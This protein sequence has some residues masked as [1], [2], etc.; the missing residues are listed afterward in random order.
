MKID[1]LA[2]NNTA[3]ALMH[4]LSTKQG[5]T[6]VMINGSS[7]VYIERDGEFIRLNMTLKRED[8][9]EFCK[10]I[11]KYNNKQ[12]DAKNP[13]ID[14]RLPDGSR[15]N[16]IS[17]LYTTGSPAITIRKYLKT[18]KTFEGSP[19]LFGIHDPKWIELFQAFVKAKYNILVSGGTGVGKTTFLNL[20]LQEIPKIERVITIEDTR[21]LQFN[22]TNV[23]RLEAKKEIVHENSGLSIRQLLKNTL[24]MRPDRIIIGEIRAE[25]AFDLLQAMN[26]GHNG[27]MASIHSNSPAESVIR[28][29][30]LF[31]LAGYEIPLRAIRFQIASAL[32]LIVQVGRDKN[33]GRVITK[34]TEVTGIEEE[35]VSMQDLG[36]YKDGELEFT[37]LVPHRMRDLIEQGMSPSFFDFNKKEPVAENPEEEA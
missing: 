2:K 1:E 19:G 7:N 22:L 3:W 9:Y 10:D 23:V 32:D 30:N 36:V 27:S 6:E 8:I 21:E 18:I 12:Y 35:K 4:E 14:G 28:L 16:I 17:S 25:E 26:T 24:R 31:L 37:G 15:V 13:I 29:E 11:A 33:G 20:L 5:I 34:V